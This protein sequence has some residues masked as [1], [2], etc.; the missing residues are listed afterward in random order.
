MLGAILLHAALGVVLALLVW[1]VGLGIVPR[2]PPIAYAVGLLAVAAAA[3]AILISPWLALVALP[4]LGGALARARPGPAFTPLARALPAALGLGIALGFL[5]RPPSATH[6]SNAYGDFLYYAQ[7]ALAARESIAPLRD[8]LVEGQ[9]S[10]YVEAAPALLGGAL[11]HVPGFDAFLFGA[12][13]LP[14][15]LVAA[16]AVGAGLTLRRLPRDTWLLALL[17]ITCIAYP[18]WLT[19][20]AP[21]ALAV[22]LAF[23]LYTLWRDGARRSEWIV[24]AIVL[25]IDVVLT[26][27][28]AAVTIA[29]FGTA[30]LVDRYGFRARRALPW[31]AVAAAV[32]AAAVALFLLTSSWLADV[33]HAKF[34]PADAVRGL[35]HQLTTRDTQSL[36]PA[37][38]VVGETLLLIALAR[39]RAWPFAAA[40]AAGIA[41]TWLVGG[42]GFDITIGL[43]VLLAVLFFAEEPESLARQ[44]PLL[45]GAALTLALSAWFRDISGVRTAFFLVALL[46]VGL[47]AMFGGRSARVAVVAALALAVAAPFALERGQTTLYAEDYRIWNAVEQLVPRDGLVFTSETGPQVTGTQGWN[48]YPGVARRHVYLAGWSN[49]SLLVRR[50]EL[51]RRLALNRRVLAGSLDPR[52]VPL[53]RTY[54]GYFAVLPARERA[55]VTFR[56]LYRNGRWA[57]YRIES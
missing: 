29:V 30:A 11:T 22:P 53:S 42:H 28:F 5:L 26:K 36:A 2:R 44:R 15:F 38:L 24:F 27:G 40:A 49:S 43:T 13:S 56:R 41:G 8:Y 52:A 39:A 20:S 47:L 57:L 12:A 50:D 48:Y 1:S 31:I 37:L 45:A 17:G 19:E 21:V 25:A 51:R 4:L 35:N 55:P 14:A 6:D 9:R 16:L 54:D 10:T 46:G 33:L 7:K 23:P 3:L 32:A 34:L 18:T